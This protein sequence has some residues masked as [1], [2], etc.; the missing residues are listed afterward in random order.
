MFAHIG[1]HNILQ[2]NHDRLHRFTWLDLFPILA[3]EILNFAIRLTLCSN[4]SFN[5]ILTQQSTSLWDNSIHNIHQ[6]IVPISD[7]YFGWNIFRIQQFT[8]PFKSSSNVIFLLRH[9][10]SKCNRERQ[11]G[12]SDT[13][14]L[15]QW[16]TIFVGLTSGIQH[17]HLENVLNNLIPFG[18]AQKISL[19]SSESGYFLQWYT[20]LF[21]T[22]DFKRCCMFVL[23]S[24]MECLYLWQAL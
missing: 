4:I 20:Y 3:F 12:R 21:S 6:R 2:C 11:V 24:L 18:C 10:I 5:L 17:K 14:K 13:N 23:G 1:I 15:K 8:T 16:K 7:N 9:H 19:I 22:N